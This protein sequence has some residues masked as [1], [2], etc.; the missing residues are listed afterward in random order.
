MIV[1][2]YQP[3]IVPIER[4]GA[5]L[6]LPDFLIKYLPQTNDFPLNAWPTYCGAGDGIGDKVIPDTELEVKFSICCL[7]H[8]I[9]WSGLFKQSRIHMCESNWRLMKNIKSLLEAN[10]DYHKYNDKDIQ[11]VYRTFFWGVMWGGMF[12]Y[13]VSEELRQPVSN[14]MNHPVVKEKVD[15]LTEAYKQFYMGGLSGK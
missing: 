3:K 12:H 5:V 15:R 4:Y 1:E 6:N 9:E 13:Y 7:G 14:P 8:D 11:R 2:D 10:V